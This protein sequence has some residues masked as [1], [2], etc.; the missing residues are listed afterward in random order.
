[1]AKKLISILFAVIVLGYATSA[2]N[3]CRFVIGS[4]YHIGQSGFDAA[5]GEPAD[6]MRFIQ[7]LNPD[8]VILTGDL[9]YNALLSEFT[10]LSNILKTNI[11]APIFELP[12][13]HDSVSNSWDGAVAPNYIG[14][15]ATFPM[16]HFAFDVGPLK[17]IGINTEIQS[18]TDP[19]PGFGKVSALE[20]SW[21]YYELQR[22][23]SEKRMPLVFGHQALDFTA[24]SDA[25]DKI[26]A[27]GCPMAFWGHNHVTNRVTTYTTCTYI[28]LPSIN[29]CPAGPVE[30]GFDLITITSTNLLMTFYKADP[31]NNYPIIWSKNYSI[32][33][34]A[35]ASLRSTSAACSAIQK[36]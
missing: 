9:T 18:S 27:S 33:V 3:I 22:A 29:T 11:T 34:P 16:K 20:K 12:G 6:N 13:N 14:W 21:L 1:M 19:T 30:G 23:L 24:D 28:E 26:V 17:F 36:P 10:T 32:N 2:Q 31:A 8:F 5:N 15:N 25:R 4:D 7:S 35:W